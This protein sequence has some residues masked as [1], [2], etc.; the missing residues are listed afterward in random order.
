MVIITTDYS[1]FESSNYTKVDFF[2]EANKQALKFIECLKD[3]PS[4]QDAINCY[5]NKSKILLTPRD[6]RNIIS[7]NDIRVAFINILKRK[8]LDYLK[9]KY[10]KQ[11]GNFIIYVDSI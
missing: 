5:Y 10:S 3:E 11:A 9:V 6:Y 1:K 7:S 4:S 2:V 8:I